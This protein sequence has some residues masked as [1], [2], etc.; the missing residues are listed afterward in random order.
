MRERSA[1]VKSTSQSLSKIQSPGRWTKT[2]PLLNCIIRTS[3]PITPL[4]V[5]FCSPPAEAL[6]PPGINEAKEDNDDTESETRVESCAERH[7]VFAPPGVVAVLDNV[8]EDV[9]NND[10]DREVEACR[11]RNPRHSTENDW[12]VD[13]PEDALAAVPAIEIER[14]R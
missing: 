8:I 13:L 5:D 11:G 1:S 10:P 3:L 2:L 14:D 12:Q 6:H 9:T 4:L 7:S